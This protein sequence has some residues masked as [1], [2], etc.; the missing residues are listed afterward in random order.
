MPVVE[1]TPSMLIYDETHKIQRVSD[2][3]RYLATC[4]RDTGNIY[5]AGELKDAIDKLETT[6]YSIQSLVAQVIKEK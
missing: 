4:L 5:L 6:A 1:K 3:F 2:D